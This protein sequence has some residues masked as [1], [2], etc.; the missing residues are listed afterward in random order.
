[1]SAYIEVM[2]SPEKKER[3][4]GIVKLRKKGWTFRKIADYYRINVK[5][6]YRAWMRYLLAE[7]KKSV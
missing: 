2:P 1:M 6:V 3:N 4:K 5:N 7:K